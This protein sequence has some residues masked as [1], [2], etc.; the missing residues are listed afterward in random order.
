MSENPFAS[1]N[2]EIPKKYS[3]EVK[4]FC[5]TAGSKVSYEFSPFNR[6]IDFWYYSFIYAVKNNLPN[7]SDN[8]TSNITP[9]SILS[10]D[11]YRITSI[12][13]AYLAATGDIEKLANHRRVF[14]Y[15]QEMANSGLPYVLQMLNDPEDRPLWSLLDSM[16]GGI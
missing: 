14:D 9:A 13:L 2:V 5:K 8:D 3:D 12:Q 10:S 16:E 6:Q 15:A 11:P 4:K 1:F 7:V